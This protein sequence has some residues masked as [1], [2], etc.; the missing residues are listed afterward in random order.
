[1]LTK[2]LLETNELQCELLMAMQLSAMILPLKSAADWHA[3]NKFMQVN[4]FVL[5]KDFKI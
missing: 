5:I 2:E 4:D 1:M 3:G